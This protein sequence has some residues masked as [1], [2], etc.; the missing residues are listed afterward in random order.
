MGWPDVAGLGGKRALDDGRVAGGHRFF[1]RATYGLH[2]KGV[3]ASGVPLPELTQPAAVSLNGP[4][5]KYGLPPSVTIS[6]TS[7]PTGAVSIG[8]QP[9]LSENMGIVVTIAPHGTA[10]SLGCSG[11]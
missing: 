3:T 7:W 8:F 9:N 11:S 10:A 4:L 1:G 2:C 6:D 5:S